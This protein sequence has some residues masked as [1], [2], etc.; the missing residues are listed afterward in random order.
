MKRAILFAI[1]IMA[2]GVSTAFAAVCPDIQYLGQFDIAQDGA[3]VARV[4][5]GEDR[6]VYVADING[7]S[8][9]VYYSDGEFIESKKMNNIVS[10]EADGDRVFVGIAKGVRGVFK[11]EV[12]VYNAALQYQFS[13]GSGYSEFTYP[14]AIAT[15]GT[16]VFVADRNAD[17]I[18][19]YNLGDGA[20]LFSFGGSGSAD[21]STPRPS[22]K[23]LTYA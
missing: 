22:A 13:L 21:S 18:K 1:V 12:K 20:Y 10:V 7:S 2:L 11:G 6:K 4:A 8:L 15:D 3:D 16:K 5:A 14:S 19:A 17:R 23:R 9:N